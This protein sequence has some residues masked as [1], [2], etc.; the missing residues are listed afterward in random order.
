MDITRRNYDACLEKAKENLMSRNPNYFM[1]GRNPRRNNQLEL[2]GADLMRPI[3]RLSIM[4]DVNGEVK[5][6]DEATFSNRLLFSHASGNEPPCCVLITDT[7]EV[8]FSSENR[9]GR[10][11]AIAFTVPQEW[12]G[13]FS[14]P[15]LVPMTANVQFDLD[16]PNQ[17]RATAV[18]TNPH[19]ARLWSYEADKLSAQ[20]RA[21]Q[22]LETKLPE[23]G[24]RN[25]LGRP[26]PRAGN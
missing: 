1:I 2:C 12:W 3:E 23:R 19:I 5:Y 10:I 26:L 8:L 17:Q 18:V 11:H 13:K 22:S 14:G 21:G 6:W 4:L 7:E 15:E 24:Y 9:N 16:N 25:E 20:A